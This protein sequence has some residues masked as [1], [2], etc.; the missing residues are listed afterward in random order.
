ML[1]EEHCTFFIISQS[2]S[3][4]FTEVKTSITKNN[5]NFAKN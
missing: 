1:Q 5:R 4:F 2:F 3:Y